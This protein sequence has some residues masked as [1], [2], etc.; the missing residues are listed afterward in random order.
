MKPPS[1]DIGPYLKVASK[2]GARQKSARA[3]RAVL[4]ILHW[5]G[6]LAI[7]SASGEMDV[8]IRRDAS[9]LHFRQQVETQRS[10]EG[11]GGYDPFGLGS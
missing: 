6:L 4:S 11:F 8:E 1:R 2:I 7:R 10:R 9:V 3:G 5:D